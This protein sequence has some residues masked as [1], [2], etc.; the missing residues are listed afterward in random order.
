MWIRDKLEPEIVERMKK[1]RGEDA[2]QLAAAWRE[3]VVVNDESDGEG[4]KGNDA[5][6]GLMPGMVLYSAEGD[7]FTVVSLSRNFVLV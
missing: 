2:E 4:K 1:Y 7:Q 6:Q 5:P 3:V